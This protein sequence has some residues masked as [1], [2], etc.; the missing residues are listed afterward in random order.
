M[1]ENEY[2]LDE[3]NKK[4]SDFKAYLLEVVKKNDVGIGLQFSTESR[5]SSVIDVVTE[6]K[7]LSEIRIVDL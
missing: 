5:K 4:V 7:V 3:L 2:T 6:V 1:N